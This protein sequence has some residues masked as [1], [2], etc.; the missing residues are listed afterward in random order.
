LSH[1]GI[2]DETFSGG[3]VGFYQLLHLI[4]G[5]LIVRPEDNNIAQRFL[6]QTLEKRV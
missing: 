4:S 5:Y 1:A 3:T 2:L 6:E